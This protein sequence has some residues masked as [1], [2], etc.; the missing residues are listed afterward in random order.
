MQSVQSHPGAAQH[1]LC[2]R[3]WVAFCSPVSCVQASNFPPAFVILSGRSDNCNGCWWVAR[4]MHHHDRSAMCPQRIRQHTSVLHRGCPSG[5]AAR[6]ARYQRRLICVRMTAQS[7]D[8][9]LLRVARGEGQ[10]HRCC[11]HLQKC[12]GSI[13]CALCLLPRLLC[14]CFADC[15]RTPVWL[16]RQ[17]GR[18]MPEFRR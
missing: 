7:P 16:M 12:A 1:G 8:P 17:A 6:L 15:E 10:A 11:I 4:Q 2:G 9:L 5:S 18:Y 14:C 13:A 3:L